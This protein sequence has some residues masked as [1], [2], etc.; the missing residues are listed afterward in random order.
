MHYKELDKRSERQQHRQVNKLL[1]NGVF[2]VFSDTSQYLFIPTDILQSEKTLS[3]D[4]VNVVQ[5]CK[6]AY[7]L[8]VWVFVLAAF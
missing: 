3:Y 7:K 6:L 5:W 4:N 1:S 8:R 2:L